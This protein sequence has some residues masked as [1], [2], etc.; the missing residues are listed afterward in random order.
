MDLPTIM[1]GEDS[2]P[3]P[4]FFARA[5]IAG[6]VSIGLKQ[7]LINEG[8]EV[9]AIT[10]DIETD[11]DDAASMGIGENSAAPLETRL[12]IRIES[13]APEAQLRPLVD[14]LLKMDPWFLA[15]RDAQSVKVALTLGA[16]KD[17]S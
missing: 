15:L 3:T 11:F 12:N 13:E 16:P 17:G 4:G 9:T 1:G 6:C 8:V 10:L 5:G 14:R 2:G 7:L